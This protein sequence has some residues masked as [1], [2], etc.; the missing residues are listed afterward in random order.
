MVQLPLGTCA[1]ILVAAGMVK[2]VLMTL[3]KQG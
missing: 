3:H 1:D 2:H